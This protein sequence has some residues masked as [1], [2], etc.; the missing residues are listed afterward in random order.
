EIADQTR[1]NDKITY[2]KLM[3]IISLTVLSFFTLKFNFVYKVT[4]LNIYLFTI[5]AIFSV[6][7]FMPKYEKNYS[8]VAAVFFFFA[9]LGACILIFAGGGLKAP[10]LFWLTLIPLFLGFMYG[11]RGSLI[12]IFLIGVIFLTYYLLYM[13]KIHINV[14]DPKNYF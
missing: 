13:N 2:F 1:N 6:T 11:T 12:G 3:N 14:I 8:V 4:S 5:L 7:L 10:G 9:C